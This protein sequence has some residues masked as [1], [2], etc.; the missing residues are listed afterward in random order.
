VSNGRPSQTVFRTTNLRNQ[1][2]ERVRVTMKKTF[3]NPNDYAS[4]IY[5]PRK[6]AYDKCH[7]G[8]PAVIGEA[9]PVSRRTVPDA[10]V[11]GILDGVAG[12]MSLLVACEQ[13]GISRESFYRW[14]REGDHQLAHDYSVAVQQQVHA[15][16]SK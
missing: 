9:L 14:M 2:R 16:F 4:L 7:F 10:T 6:L 11:R 1:L 5:E 3:D 13:A 12:G 8:E 15:R